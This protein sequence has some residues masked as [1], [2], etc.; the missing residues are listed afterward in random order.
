MLRLLTRYQVQLAGA[1]LA[2]WAGLGAGDARVRRQ[3]IS[4]WEAARQQAADRD[5][6]RGC[7]LDRSDKGQELS[8][9]ASMPD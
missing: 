1:H 4:G 9:L 6:G 7:R 2:A 8:V 5:A 3:K